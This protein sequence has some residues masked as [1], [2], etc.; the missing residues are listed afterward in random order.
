MGRSLQEI[1]LSGLTTNSLPTT[2]LLKDKLLFPTKDLFFLLVTAMKAPLMS[3]ENIPT[4]VNPTVVLAWL[5]K[6]SLIIFNLMSGRIPLST[7]RL[8]MNARP[9][10]KLRSIHIPESCVTINLGCDPP[11]RWTIRQPNIKVK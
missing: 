1:P 8:G 6:L 7:L 11:E 10:N 3:L 9:V 5:V 4:T 2:L